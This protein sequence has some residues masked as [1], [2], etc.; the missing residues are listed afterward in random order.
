M[1]TTFTHHWQI[2]GHDWAV[3]H[4]QQSMAYERIRHGYLFVGPESVG[5]ETLARQFAMALNCTNPDQRAV[6]AVFRRAAASPPAITRMCC[7]RSAT[8]RPARSK[9]KNCA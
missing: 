9:S 7:T 4:L 2:Y 8:P 1:T 6:R 3:A 5:K